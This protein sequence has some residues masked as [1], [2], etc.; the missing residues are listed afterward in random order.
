[1]KPENILKLLPKREK[2]ASKGDFGHALI[3]GGD[4]GMAGAVRMAGEACARVGAG[5]TSVVSHE[6]HVASIITER[7]ELMAHGEKDL[8]DLLKKANV[9]AIGPG[10]G[11]GE[12]GQQLLATVLATDLPIIMDADALNL[13]AQQKTKIANWILTPHPGEASRLLACSI[14]DIQQ[15]RTKAAKALQKTYGGV[16]VL[17]GA[18]TVVCGENH[19][20]FINTTGNP[21]MASGGMGDVLTGVITGFVAQGLHLYDAACLGVYCHGKAGDLAAEK[22]ERGLLAT[23]VIAH[24]RD[25]VNP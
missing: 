8:H 7:P 1:M 2:D 4:Y 9:I 21:G 19:P 23:D 3:I 5:L 10:L 6:D 16:V 17:K 11:T 15:D 20:I 14:D 24:L 25:V 13:L 22:G 12:W 18:G